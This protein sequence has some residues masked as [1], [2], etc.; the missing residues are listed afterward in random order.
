MY[1]KNKKNHEIFNICSNR[2]FKLVKVL[3]FLNSLTNMPRIKK[4]KIQKAD[5]LKTHGSNKKIIKFLRFKKFT[6][7]NKGLFN[8]FVW[9]SNYLKG[10][11]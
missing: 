1:L 3:N 4:I 10:K 5:V 11:L 9:Y 7:L 8:T 2:P 6:N